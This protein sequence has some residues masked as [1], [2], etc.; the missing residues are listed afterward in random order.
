[1][2]RFLTSVRAVT[3][4]KDD[5]SNAAAAAADDDD[6]ETTA[7]PNKTPLSST[8]KQEA[9]AM[10]ALSGD[11]A[12]EH[13]ADDSKV[14]KAKVNQALQELAKKNAEERQRRLVE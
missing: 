6:D 7:T 8:A 9:K 12:A 10:Q 3:T 5:D 14:D 4:R 2:L 1:L 11:S 13:A